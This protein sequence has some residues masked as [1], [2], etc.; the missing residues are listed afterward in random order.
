MGFIDEKL[1]TSTVFIVWTIAST[2][3]SHQL[4]KGSALDIPCA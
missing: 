2:C 1:R 4:A 3:L